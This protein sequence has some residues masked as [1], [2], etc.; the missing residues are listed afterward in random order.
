[1]AHSTLCANKNADQR[2]QRRAEIWTENVNVRQEPDSDESVGYDAFC[3]RCEERSMY[4]LAPTAW[5]ATV[6][7]SGVGTV[8]LRKRVAAASVN[9][10][11]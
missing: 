8:V 1:M 3:V 11:L 2:R 10:K 5:T 6:K 9:E 4:H 7:C